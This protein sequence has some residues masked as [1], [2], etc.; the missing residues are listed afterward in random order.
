MSSRS[1]RVAG[2]KASIRVKMSWSI[3]IYYLTPLRKDRLWDK[4]KVWFAKIPRGVNLIDTF[5]RRMVKQR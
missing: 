4:T 1:L 5:V 2:F 3:I